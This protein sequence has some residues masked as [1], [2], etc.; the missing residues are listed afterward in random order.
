MVSLLRY[1]VTDV[2]TYR[3]PLTI[4]SSFSHY[5]R[6]STPSTLH[7]RHFVLPRY[8]STRSSRRRKTEA[9]HTSNLPAPKGTYRLLYYKGR[10]RNQLCARYLKYSMCSTQFDLINKD[11]IIRNA[12]INAHNLPKNRLFLYNYED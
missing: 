4:R 11:G 6:C 10:H 8:L 2:D 5:F 9:L 7:C 1:R 12:C 3:N